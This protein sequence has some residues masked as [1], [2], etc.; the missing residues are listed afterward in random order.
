MGLFTNKKKLCPICGNPTPRLFPREFDAQPICKE[1]ENKIDLPGEI[2]DN[3]TLDGFRQ[4][5]AA[6]E[7]NATLRSIFHETY[8]YGGGLFSSNALLLDEE[9]GLIRLKTTPKGWAIEKQYLKSFRIFEDDNLLFESGE[10]TLNSYSSEIPAQAKALEPVVRTFYIEKQAYE[11]REQLERV[12]S[13]NETDE[14]RRERE[15]VNRMYCPRFE[16]P[17][18]FSGFRVEITLEHPYWTS[19]EET[20]GAP[21]F[22]DWVPSIDDYL[23]SYQKS[24]DDLHLLAAKL[25]HMID[26]DAGETQIESAKAQTTYSAAAAPV[27]AVA[28]IQR[29][30][31]LMEQGII[32]EEEFTAKKRQLLGI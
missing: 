17:K 30:K 14:E 11:R 7:E 1:C 21:A 15:R 9:N 27:D 32:T 23:K 8:R 20:S 16:E 26:S 28:E 5:L 22:D 6:Y 12:R 25:M 29:F 3:M 19:Y 10:G 31:D 2:L 24:V 13:M 4:Y 18:L